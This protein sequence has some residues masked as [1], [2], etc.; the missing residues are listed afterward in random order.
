VKIISFAD[1]RFKLFILLSIIALI[2]HRIIKVY[3]VINTGNVAVN[4][5]HMSLNSYVI[6]ETITACSWGCSDFK[7]KIRAKLTSIFLQY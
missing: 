7:G 2:Y 3:T 5:A 1:Y 6:L 4:Q